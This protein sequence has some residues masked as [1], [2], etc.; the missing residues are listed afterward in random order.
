MKIKHLVVTT[1][2]GPS[3]DLVR[4]S[5]YV[6]NYASANRACEVSLLMP[7]RAQSYSGN[8]LPPAFSMSLPEGYLAHRLV[9]RLAKFEKVDDM[10]LLSITG[11]HQIG[12]LKFE[13]PAAPRSSKRAD[14]GL[15]QLLSD[16]ASHEIFE[17]L[18]ETYFDSGIS[19]MQPKVMIPD[20]DKAY[21]DRAT[22][23][24]SDLIVKTG[25]DDYPHLSV[26]EFLCM[27]AA[28]RAGISVPDFWL[29]DDG[30]LFVMRRFDLA[31][32]MQLGFEDM[33]VLMNKP[34]EPTGHYK[35][36]QSYED[37]ARI[38]RVLCGDQAPESL[39][40]FYEAL[41]LSVA[42]RNGDAH[43]KNFG[44]LYD[45][46][47]AGTAPRLS[48]LYDVVTT[49]AYDDLN[50]RTGKMQTDRTLALKLNKSKSYPTREALVAFGKQH[51]HVWA[52]EK[53]IERIGDAMHDTLSAHGS[54]VEP[55]FFDRMK[56]EW[57]DGLASISPPRKHV[58]STTLRP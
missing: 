8:L 17:Q 31:G 24:H 48:P 26:N 51:C 6:F 54:R 43:L 21:P 5:Q 36:S 20:A 49:A 56:R 4:E 11:H 14:I 47:A 35:Y 37:I 44:L 39:Q 10:R 46:P 2:Q 15:K 42:V 1:P 22:V 38:I 58:V 9:D 7:L 16:R 18:V 40:R 33:T 55:A 34:R 13:T 45:H 3:G 25:G 32:G 28:R 19:G 57:H 12:R 27:E 29:S 52:A 30:A 41:V 50:L 23:V 53:T